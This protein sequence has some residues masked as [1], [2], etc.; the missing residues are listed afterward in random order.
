MIFGYL[1]PSYQTGDTETAIKAF[2]PLLETDP[3]LA[4]QVLILNVAKKTG[5]WIEKYYLKAGNHKMAK[6]I[7]KLYFEACFPKQQTKVKLSDFTEKPSLGVHVERT[8]SNTIN[9]L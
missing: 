5:N 6:T 4:K 7:Q 8:T 9:D 1:F 2:E 3:F